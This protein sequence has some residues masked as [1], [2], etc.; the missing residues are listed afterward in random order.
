M[1]SLAIVIVWS[2]SIMFS[3]LYLGVHTL[4]DIIAA[5]FL[6]QGL[7]GAFWFFYSEFDELMVQ[8]VR[9]PSACAVVVF[10]LLYTFPRS[11]PS[12]TTFGDCA[13]TLGT[14]NGFIFGRH[15]AGINHKAL[16]EDYFNSISLSTDTP[17]I[18]SL[19][20]RVL[21]RIIVGYSLILATRAV[22]KLVFYSIFNWFGVVLGW[23]CVRYTNKLIEK[24]DSFCHISEI[25]AI[26]PD[27]R[28]VYE[29]YKKESLP[30][31]VKLVPLTRF[32]DTQMKPHTFDLDI[33]VKL[34]SYFIVCWVS[35]V[36]IPMIF[37]AYV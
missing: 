21:V 33:P 28:T 18:T 20:W 27:G 23:D 36:I 29:V 34:C 9:V 1:I 24:Q 10:F 6:A 32:I 4:I 26:T 30:S 14:A 22:C 15:F 31:N 3:R 2:C 8:D 17:E 11:R 25:F 7:L 19:F 16:F 5:V 37:N 12:T 13:T 35:I